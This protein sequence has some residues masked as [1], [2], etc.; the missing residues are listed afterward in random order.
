MSQDSAQLCRGHDAQ[1]APPPGDLL[2]PVSQHHR[3]A[4]QTGLGCAEINARA[5]EKTITVKLHYLL[6]PGV[7]RAAAE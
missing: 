5:Q 1:S 7:A 2:I 4:E 3:A 6:P